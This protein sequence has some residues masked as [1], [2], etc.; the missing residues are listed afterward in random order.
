MRV[1]S[2]WG[3]VLSQESGGVRQSIAYV[4]R[5]LSAQERK[6]SS[7]YELE[8]LAVIFGPEKFR[9]CI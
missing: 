2:L 8:Y 5:T 1:V 7:T 3:A 6:A 4:S 9:K